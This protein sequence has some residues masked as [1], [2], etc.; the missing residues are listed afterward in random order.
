MSQEKMGVP[1]PEK[2]VKEEINEGLMQY[3]E[4]E[5]DREKIGEL[6]TEHPEKIGETFG[7]PYM[8]AFTQAISEGKT[9]QDADKIALKKCDEHDS[10]DE[11]S[12]FCSSNR[13][14]KVLSANKMT[15]ASRSGTIYELTKLEN[16]QFK[17]VYPDNS[18]L[19]FDLSLVNLSKEEADKK[20]YDYWMEDG[21]PD[22]AKKFKQ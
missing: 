8:E 11:S 10:D 13:S 3:N 14:G 18:S 4:K 6:V 22:L 16:G 5:N 1:T 2:T 20:R 7:G 9:F 19:V 21:R 17:F 15:Y 12:S